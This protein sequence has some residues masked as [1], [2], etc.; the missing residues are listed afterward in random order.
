MRQNSST[1]LALSRH[2][3]EKGEVTTAEGGEEGRGS[4]GSE[5]VVLKEE[6]VVV[7]EEEAGDE[8][9]KGEGGMAGVTVV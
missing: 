6:G 7:T 5:G 2:D 1:C 8:S 4:G 3:E 9:D